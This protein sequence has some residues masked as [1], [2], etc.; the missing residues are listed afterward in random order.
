MKILECCLLQILLGTLRVKEYQNV[1]SWRKKK[2]IN[3]FGFKLDMC[4]YK[5]LCPQSYACP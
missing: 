4:V 2:S 5:T 3:P 1:F